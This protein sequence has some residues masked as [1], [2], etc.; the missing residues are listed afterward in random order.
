MELP[1]IT[2][3]PRPGTE[4]LHLDGKNIGVCVIDFWRWSASDLL[5]NATRGRFAEFIIAN[6]LGIPLDEVLR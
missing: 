1:R 3:Q 6:A 2:Q 4:Q 5:S